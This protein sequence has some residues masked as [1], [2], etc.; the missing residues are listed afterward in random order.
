MCGSMHHSKEMINTKQ[1]LE[2]IGFIVE[3]PKNTE[4]YADKTLPPE[5]RQESAANKIHGDLLKKYFEII[6]DSDAI[7]VVNFEKHNIPNYIGRN[8]FL[9]M[10]FAHILDKPI[11]LENPIPEMLYKDEIIAMQPTI[12]NGN[13]TKLKLIVPQSSIKWQT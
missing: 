10:A 2:K 13:L 8:T 6:K 7:F 11:Y 5:S 1:K 12:L 3:I 4:Y 9:E